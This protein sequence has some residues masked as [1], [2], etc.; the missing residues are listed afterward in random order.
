MPEFFHDKLA[1][2]LQGSTPS[3]WKHFNGGIRVLMSHHDR[4]PENCRIYSAGKNMDFLPEISLSYIIFLI[5]VVC[6]AQNLLG[7]PWHNT[8]SMQFNVQ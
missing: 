8:L 2:S 5:L 1:D 3:E 4:I 7:R 6:E